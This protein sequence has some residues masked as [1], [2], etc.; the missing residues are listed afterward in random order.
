M[1]V[2]GNYLKNESGEIFS[3]VVSTDTI[4]YNGQKLTTLLDDIKQNYLYY[5]VLYNK[6]TTI[7]SRQSGSSI[8]INLNVSNIL[9]SIDTLI[10]CNQHRVSLLSKRSDESR[11]AQTARPIA[12]VDV[13]NWSNEYTNIFGFY[14]QSP[15]SSSLTLSG[16]QLT[17]VIYTGEVYTDS[18]YTTNVDYIY[19]INLNS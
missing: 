6:T 19:G 12:F 14:V 13:S 17:K 11:I 2:K 18:T 1:N 3:P 7:P 8:T 4:Y 16:S 10:F 9:N 15:N 5:K